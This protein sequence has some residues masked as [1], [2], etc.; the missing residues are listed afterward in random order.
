MIFVELS[1]LIK[2]AK[3]FEINYKYKYFAFFTITRSTQLFFKFCA[4]AIFFI[5][6]DL[7]CCYFAL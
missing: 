1:S 7:N 6:Q 5:Y 4:D 3:L 2:N